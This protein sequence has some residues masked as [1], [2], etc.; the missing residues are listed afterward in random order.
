MRL[1]FNVAACFSVL[2]CAAQRMALLLLFGFFLTKN[3]ACQRQACRVFSSNLWFR[4]RWSAHCES[5]DTSTTLGVEHVM[6]VSAL[7]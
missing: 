5:G 1:D 4:Y 7:V 2:A 3:Q 6:V